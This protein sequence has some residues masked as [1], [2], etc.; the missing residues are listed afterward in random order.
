MQSTASSSPAC[1]LNSAF[2]AILHGDAD[3]IVPIADSALLS[4]KIVKK[5]T[6]KIVPG[7]P[8][9]MCDPC[10]KSERRI[11]NA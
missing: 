6:L 10:G 5:A 9:G 4:L 11:A 2:A 7:A 1:R 8:H 3:Q